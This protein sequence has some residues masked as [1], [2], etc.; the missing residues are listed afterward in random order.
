VILAICSPSLL[1]HSPPL[2]YHSMRFSMSY[3]W[4]SAEEC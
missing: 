1:A 4:M 2:F 3:E